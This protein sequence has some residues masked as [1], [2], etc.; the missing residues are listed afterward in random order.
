[1]WHVTLFGK[2]NCKLHHAIFFFFPQTYIGKVVVS[3]NPYKK[4]P[5]YS[6]EKIKEYQGMNIYEVLPHMWVLQNYTV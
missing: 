2:F 3:M 5:L 4:L 1:M 6:P